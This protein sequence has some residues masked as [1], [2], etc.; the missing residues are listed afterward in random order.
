MLKGKPPVEAIAEELPEDA[1]A[2]PASLELEA[3]LLYVGDTMLEG[4]PPVDPMYDA[5]LLDEL[6]T[7]LDS[8]GLELLE[9]LELGVG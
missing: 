1:L 3:A 2:G 4:R 8:I 9:L 5:L 6:P 7:S